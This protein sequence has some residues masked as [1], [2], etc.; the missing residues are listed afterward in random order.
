MTMEF[1]V[2]NESL[3]QALK[4]VQRRCPSSSSS[5]SRANG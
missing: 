1:K 2:A 4:P 5:V 3:L